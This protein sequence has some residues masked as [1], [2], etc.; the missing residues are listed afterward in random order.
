ME[1]NISPTEEHA[2]VTRL[3]AAST[4]I[5]GAAAITACAAASI[6]IIAMISQRLLTRSPNGT[7]KPTPTNMPP[8]DSVGTQP[9]AA[10]LA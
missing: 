8:N 1:I 6:E 4:T 10:G 9:T 5:D 7:N 3:A 2:P